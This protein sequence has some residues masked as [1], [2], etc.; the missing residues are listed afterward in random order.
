MR[1]PILFGLFL[2]W[3]L[4]WTAPLAAYCE[5]F[6]RDGERRFLVLSRDQ[7]VGEHRFR[8]ERRGDDFVV[9]VDVSF[10]LG[11]TNRRTAAIPD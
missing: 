10:A 8:F 5:I 1:K 3:P 4:Y 7:V 11:P 6:P 9:R 2:L